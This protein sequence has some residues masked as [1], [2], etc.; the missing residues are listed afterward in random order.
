MRGQFCSIADDVR[1]GRDVQIH[2]FVNLYGC[3]I[4]DETRV[5]TFVE[6]QRGARVGRRCKISS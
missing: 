5:G 4:G 1:L 6:I 2:N 3:E